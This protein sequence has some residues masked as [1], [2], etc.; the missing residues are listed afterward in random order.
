MLKTE[1]FHHEL[2]DDEL[3]SN[4][5][6]ILPVCSKELCSAKCYA[7]LQEIFGAFSLKESVLSLIP[8]GNHKQVSYGYIVIVGLQNT[9]REK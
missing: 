4:C 1:L 3:I 7:E 8:F 6:G 5:S 9:F 2:L